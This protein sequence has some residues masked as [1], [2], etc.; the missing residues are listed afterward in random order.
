MTNKD[1]V[2]IAFLVSVGVFSAQ[3]AAQYVKGLS[4]VQKTAFTSLSVNHSGNVL[5]CS[6]NTRLPDTRSRQG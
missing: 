5:L 1:K 6:D 3:N 2:I 4:S